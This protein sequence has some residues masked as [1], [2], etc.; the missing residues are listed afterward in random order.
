MGIENIEY[1]TSKGVV[2]IFRLG[3]GDISQRLSYLIIKYR[4][5]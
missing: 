3:A 5:Q 1:K 2:K 4:T